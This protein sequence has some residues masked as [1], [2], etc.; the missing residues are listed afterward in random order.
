MADMPDQADG[1]SG[2]W[3]FFSRLYGQSDPSDPGHQT[4]V[5]AIDSAEE[6]KIGMGRLFEPTTKISER[7]IIV[8][9]HILES[10]ELTAGQNLTFHYDIK[11]LLNTMQTLTGKIFPS[12]LTKET[13]LA[14]L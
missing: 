14:E 7:E 8:S 12:F 9:D 10:L 6:L 11:M 5:F 1:V 3:T 13:T 2:R 4:T